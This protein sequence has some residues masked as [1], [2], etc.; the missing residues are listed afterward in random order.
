MR[1]SQLLG[2]PVYDRGGKRMGKCHDIR[3]VQRGPLGRRDALTV[4]G[5]VVGKGAL[6][7]RLGYGFTT[8][9]PWLLD[10]TLGRLADRARFVAWNDLEVHADRIVVTAPVES[11]RHPAEVDAEEENGGSAR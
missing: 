7:S 2:T 4:T 1:A 6:G 5:I 9:G 3:A 11:L 10:V 8:K